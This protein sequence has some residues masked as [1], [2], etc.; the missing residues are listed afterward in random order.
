MAS[1]SFDVAQ[2]DPELVE[3][4]SSGQKD[5]EVVRKVAMSQEQM[6]TTAEYFR[7]TGSRNAG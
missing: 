7:S 1:S 3:G 5:E 2:D 4:S 6:M